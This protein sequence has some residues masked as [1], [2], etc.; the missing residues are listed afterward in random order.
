MSKI[1]WLLVCFAS[2][3]VVQVFI[4][5]SWQTI[6]LD[7]V[8]CGTSPNLTRLHESLGMSVATTTTASTKDTTEKII[9]DAESLI[10]VGIHPRA[11]P[12][13]DRP[14]PCFEPEERWW[15][16]LVQ[17]TPSQ[18]GLLFLKEMKVGSSTMV[19][20]VIRIARNMARR[21][22][23]DYR[24]CKARFDHSSALK[25]QYNK[26]DRKRSFLFTVI[27]DPASRATSQ[28]FH[29]AVSRKKIEPSDAN[30]QHHLTVHPYLDHYY[31]R[32][33]GVQPFTPGTSNPIIAVN[34]ILRQYNFIGVT[35]R[36]DESLV[37][38][39]MILGLQTNDML[40]L[41]AKGKG[42]Y[43]DGAA[44]NGTC[45]YIVPSFVSP[46]MKEFFK[47]DTWQNRTFGDQLLY[48]AA[49]V[50]LDL[51]I[52]RLGRDEFN[53]KL[54]KFKKVMAL[55]QDTCQNVRFPCSPAGV[56]N[57]VTDC[58]WLDSGC[59]VQCLDSLPETE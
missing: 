57:N 6:S 20:V 46:G 54:R 33:L 41:R 17:R 31:L 1:P 27:R 37:S 30:F 44:N 14:F 4:F 18:T 13:W 38:L 58:I 7:S 25:L 48:E 8:Y 15:H 35:E 32:D 40:Y 5:W 49:K 51:T 43:D 21:L 56:K 29:F 3:L 28:F 52:D 26:R 19:G 12:I 16:P 36:M 34:N 10:K 11:F 45:H 53:Q 9:Y 59:G 55:A 42:G 24:L 39:Q 2:F 22:G 50:S 23:T 47:S